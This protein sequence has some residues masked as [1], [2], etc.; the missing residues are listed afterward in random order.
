[1]SLFSFQ[2]VAS[3]NQDHLT[4]AV[5]VEIE[6]AFGGW[7]P[8]SITVWQFASCLNKTVFWST[9]DNKQFGFTTEEQ[10]RLFSFHCFKMGRSIVSTLLC[11][12]LTILIKSFWLGVRNLMQ[13]WELT[14]CIVTISWLKYIVLASKKIVYLYWGHSQLNVLT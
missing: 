12:T 5:A 1:M 7:V 11:T 9:T 10:N 8:P 3:L 4:L 6:K 13:K 2:A 14:G